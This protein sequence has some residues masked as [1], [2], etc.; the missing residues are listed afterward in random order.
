MIFIYYTSVNA[1]MNT[2]NNTMQQFYVAIDNGP[3]NSIIFE[4]EK[5]VLASNRNKLKHGK[6][7]I[8]MVILHIIL[9]KLQLYRLLSSFKVFFSHSL[10]T[11]SGHLI[12]DPAS[13]R[14]RR[15][16]DICGASEWWAATGH[17]SLAKRGAPRGR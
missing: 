10:E 3:F 4:H 17:P 16:S 8:L 5:G 1:H 13:H 15:G 14:F 6:C 12:V 11:N 2:H 9:L 7:K